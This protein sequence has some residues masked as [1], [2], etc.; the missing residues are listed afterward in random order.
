[1]LKNDNLADILYT[2]F[3]R[4]FYSAKASTFAGNPPTGW[5]LIPLS[6]ISDFQYG[7]MVPESERLETGYPIFSGYGI[8]GYYHEYMFD[9]PH[10]IVLARGVSGT[11]EVRISPPKSYI[12]NLSI[13]LSLKDDAY[14]AYLYEYLAHDNLRSLDSGSAQ[15]MITIDNLGRHI[16]AIP[17]RERAL[18][19]NNAATN[20][21]ASTDTNN[22]ELSIL[23]S[24]SKI[25]LT[26]LS[27]S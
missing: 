23:E 25:Q 10:I 7:K 11:G 13:A 18:A 16:I 2:E 12:T 22:K 3:C 24:L 4:E 26:Q 9:A 19:F 14:F 27:S 21:F 20:F 6:D 17:P 8:T 1:M 15:S 5:R